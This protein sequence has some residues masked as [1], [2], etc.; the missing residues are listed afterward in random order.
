MDSGQQLLFP[1]QNKFEEM[2][3]SMKKSMILVVVSLCLIMTACSNEFAKQEYDFVDKIV[4][5]EDRYAKET[6]IFN[7]IEGGYSLTV[8]KFDGRETLWSTVLE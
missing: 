1:V 7:P 6:S 5:Q 2:L 3:D 8:S 4:Q